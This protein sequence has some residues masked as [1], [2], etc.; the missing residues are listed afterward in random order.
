VRITRAKR[1][2]IRARRAQARGIAAQSRSI[3]KKNNYVKFIIYPIL[4]LKCSIASG[5]VLFFPS[6]VVLNLLRRFIAAEVKTEKTIGLFPQVILFLS[7]GT[8]LID[9]IICGCAACFPQAKARGY[10]YFKR[11]RSLF[12]SEGNGLK[13]IAINSNALRV[14]APK[15]LLLCYKIDAKAVFFIIN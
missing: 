12:F 7:K 2:E 5:S 9:S 11:I 6:R 3:I 14:A 4:A 1:Y 10:S 13:P 15:R 8:Y